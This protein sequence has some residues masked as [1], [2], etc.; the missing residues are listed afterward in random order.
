MSMPIGIA[1]GRCDWSRLES[2]S[3]RMDRGG[4]AWFCIAAGKS[5]LRDESRGDDLICIA[6]GKPLLQDES[7]G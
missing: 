5:L 7:R 6:A 2:R 3:Y 4:M 1:D